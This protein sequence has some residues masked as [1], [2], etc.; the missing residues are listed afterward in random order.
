M[1][2][3]FEFSWSAQNPLSIMLV[4]MMAFSAEAEFFGPK[5]RHSIR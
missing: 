1:A 3:F 5:P 4:Q 2:H